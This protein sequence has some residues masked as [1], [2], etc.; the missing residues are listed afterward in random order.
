MSE[1]N[2]QE[3]SISFKK[4]KGSWSHVKT[5]LG[6]VAALLAGHTWVNAKL[7]AIEQSAVDISTLKT[8]A[9]SLRE[10]QADIN[11]RVAENVNISRELIIDELNV[12][13]NV[14]EELR[15]DILA[16]LNEMRARHGVIPLASG[17]VV[18]Q[19]D[20]PRLIQEAQDEVDTSITRSSVMQPT[21]PP[22][23]AL[24]DL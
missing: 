14:D 9:S 2:P 21:A 19:H 7:T 6:V 23:M 4:L 22:L 11:E 13:D 15:H 24:D 20:M 12:R 16:I 1:E 3:H 8:A 10:E 18:R 17:G 5:I